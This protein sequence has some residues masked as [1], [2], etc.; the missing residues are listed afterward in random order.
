MAADKKS[1]LLYCDLIHSIEKMPDEKAGVLFKHILRYVNDQ[2]PVTDDLLIEVAFEHIKQSLKRDLAKYESTRAK[3]KQNAEKRWNK[4]NANECDRIP[5]D[6]KH[7]DSDSDSDSDSDIKSIIN[8]TL[9]ETFVSGAGE[10][11]GINSKAERFDWTKLVEQFNTLTG[12]NS[13]VVPE[14]AKKQIRAL[15]KI[16]YTKDDIIT[17]IINCH[18]D[19]YHIS[20]NHKHLTIEFITRPDK[21]EKYLSLKTS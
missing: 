13:K 18:K 1:F 16:G 12:K 4:Q 8:N 7:A 3:N 9:P 5:T 6:T 11:S 14:K 21:M 19:P 15:I 20:E 17:A 2:N 10:P